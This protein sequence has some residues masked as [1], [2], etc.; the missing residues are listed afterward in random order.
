MRIYK[1]AGKDQ[2]GSYNRECYFYNETGGYVKDQYFAGAYCEAF[3]KM[4][5]R[6][7]LSG[8]KP[9][10]VTRTPKCKEEWPK[11]VIVTGAK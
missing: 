8:G 2:C 7:R 10:L 11:G 1:V 6:D 3:K 9:V 5:T 4:L